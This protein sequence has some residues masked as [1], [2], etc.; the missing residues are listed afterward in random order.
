MGAPHRQQFPGRT[1]QRRGKP[2][3]FNLPEGCCVRLSRHGHGSIRAH[4]TQTIQAGGETVGA[5]QAGLNCAHFR[6]RRWTVASC[7]CGCVRGRRRLGGRHRSVG[8]SA[9]FV[10]LSWKIVGRKRERGRAESGGHRLLCASWGRKGSLISGVR[11]RSGSGE[12][13]FSSKGCRGRLS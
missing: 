6:P 4:P 7:R 3:P 5:T 13:R 8:G 10:G 12:S 2:W 1:C 9:A 11:L